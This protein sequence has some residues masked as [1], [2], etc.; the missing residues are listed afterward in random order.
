MDKKVKRI[1]SPTENFKVLKGRIMARLRNMVPNGRRTA[2]YPLT[3]FINSQLF[4]AA[5]N[6]ITGCFPIV[7]GMAARTPI[8]VNSRGTNERWELVLKPKQGRYTFRGIFGRNNLSLLLFSNSQ[9][10][11]GGNFNR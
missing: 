1:A 2:L 4:S 6:K 9:S 3:C 11:P 8:T 5:D 10:N 7:R